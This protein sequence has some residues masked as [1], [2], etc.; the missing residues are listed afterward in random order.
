MPSLSDDFQMP[1]MHQDLRNPG[2]GMLGM[3]NPYF[4]MYTNYLGGIRMQPELQNDKV[5]FSN[6]ALKERKTLKVIGTVIASVA[7]LAF[8]KGKGVFGAISKG[9]S[10]AT[11]WVKNLFKKTPKS[12]SSA[13]KT[14]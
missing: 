6:R 13:T 10:S 12:V 4:G 7:G 8:L 9:Y 14:T 2:M 3:P 5:V 1:I 11:N